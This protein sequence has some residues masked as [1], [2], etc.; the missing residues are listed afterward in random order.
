MI[1]PWKFIGY[2]CR[3]Y[4]MIVPGTRDYHFL[5][6]RVTSLGEL[7]RQSQCDVG[8]LALLWGESLVVHN[9]GYEECIK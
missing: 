5:L 1:N 4:E 6:E 9:A 3:D 8:K 7:W 2:Q